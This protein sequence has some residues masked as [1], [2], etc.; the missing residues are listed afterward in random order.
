MLDIKRYKQY[1]V[2]LVRDLLQVFT[3]KCTSEKCPSSNMLRQAHAMYVLR[4]HNHQCPNEYLCK[5][6]AIQ[7]RMEEIGIGDMLEE[8]PQAKI[9][10]VC[11][12][13]MRGQEMLT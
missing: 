10:D 8:L 7:R 13:Y 6:C 5:D 1:P 4:A 2:S 9:V 11:E 12:E 3:L